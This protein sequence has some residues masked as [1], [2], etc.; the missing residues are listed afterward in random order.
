VPI[1]FPSNLSNESRCAP[2][3]DFKTAAW[4]LAVFNFCYYKSFPLTPRFYI[5][6]NACCYA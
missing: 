3:A 2:K 6:Y 1:I 5:Y 4:A